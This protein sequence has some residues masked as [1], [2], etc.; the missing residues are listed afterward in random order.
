ME[1]IFFVFGLTRLVTFMEITRP[2]VR[3]MVCVFFVE[4]K[5]TMMNEK[6]G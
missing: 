4:K 5:H 1:I 6:D 2:E 3:G